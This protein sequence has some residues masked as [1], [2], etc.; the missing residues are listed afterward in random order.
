MKVKDTKLSNIRRG[1]IIM[2]RAGSLLW[3]DWD[4]LGGIISTFEGNN[5]PD[6]NGDGRSDKG[7]SDGDYT[8]CAWVEFSPN[9]EAEVI[10]VDPDNFKIKDTIA[11]TVHVSMPTKWHDEVIEAERLRANTG[12]RVHATW[13]TVRQETID[14]ENPHMEVW[15]L[16][17]ATPEIIEGIFKQTNDML[18]FGKIPA[19]HYDLAE[20]MSF[21]IFH[22]PSAKICSEFIAEP[23]Y[24]ASLLCGDKVPICLTPDLKMN[25]DQ[26]ITPNDLINSGEMFKIAYQGVL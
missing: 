5:G 9:P 24:Y 4:I 18:A 17:R 23:A 3:P 26:Q 11:N 8:H 7:Y 14:W 6:R 25:R 22:L 12:V 21:G 13:P 15:R 2:Y 16:R 20:F 1:D 10:E 19:Y